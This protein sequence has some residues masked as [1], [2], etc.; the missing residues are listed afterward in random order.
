VNTDD[1][2]TF[3]VFDVTLIPD[4]SEGS[5]GCR[6]RSGCRILN[7]MNGGCV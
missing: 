6:T 1:D 7:P 3:E 4:A 2:A 5:E